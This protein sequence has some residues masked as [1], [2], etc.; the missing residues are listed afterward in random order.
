ME[1]LKRLLGVFSTLTLVTAC[2]GGS[3]SSSAQAPVA[4]AGAKETVQELTLVT[5][6]GS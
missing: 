4:N 2:G 5:L 3:S 6:S 1:L